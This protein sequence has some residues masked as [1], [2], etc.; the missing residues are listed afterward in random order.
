M[1]SA[2][3]PKQSVVMTLNFSAVMGRAEA[4][5]SPQSS[6]RA[7]GFPGF[8][9]NTSTKGCSN[10][11][12]ITGASEMMGTFSSCAVAEAMWCQVSKSEV[13]S[14]LTP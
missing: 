7:E 13:A 11:A 2:G 10:S 9:A 1:G 6:E 5:T 8:A 12:S 4:E 3:L 14:L